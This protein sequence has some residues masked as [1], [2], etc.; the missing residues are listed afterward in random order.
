[1]TTAGCGSAPGPTE[2]PRLPSVTGTITLDGATSVPENAVLAVRL[3]DLQRTGPARV[4][5]EQLVSSP[6]K[7]P[8][9]YRLYYHQNSIDYSRD[10][11]VEAVVSVFGR[12]TWTQADPNPVLTKDRPVVA[13]VLLKRVHE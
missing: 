9:H 12:P 13:D 3:V 7:F 6:D 4:V 11:G 1:M 10:Y 5:I 8:Y 2:P